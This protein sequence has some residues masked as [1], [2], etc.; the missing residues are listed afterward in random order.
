MPTTE[1]ACIAVGIM[2][3]A[4]TFALGLVVGATMRKGV[5]HGSE[6]TKADWWHDIERR[7]TEEVLAGGCGR[8]CKPRHQT[9]FGQRTPG[10]RAPDG[11]ES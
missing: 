7:R 6:G 9:G 4:A 3:Q 1:V 11:D 2:V 8:G 5:Q 10:R